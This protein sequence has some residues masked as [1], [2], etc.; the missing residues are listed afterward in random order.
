MKTPVCWAYP[1][2][3]PGTRGD[4]GVLC[5]GQGTGWDQTQP[6]HIKGSTY[7]AHYLNGYLWKCETGESEQWANLPGVILHAVITVLSLIWGRLFVCLDLP[8]RLCNID[9]GFWLSSLLWKLPQTDT[10]VSHLELIG[11]RSAVIFN[12]LYLFSCSAQFDLWFLW[13]LCM[14]EYVN[15]FMCVLV[16][17]WTSSCVK[18]FFGFIIHI[19]N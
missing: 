12:E 5:C 19:V 4:K 7:P 6:F 14:N 8:A 2:V 11:C 3:W 16:V 9:G 17:P 13:G 1:A 18:T 10:Q 15:S